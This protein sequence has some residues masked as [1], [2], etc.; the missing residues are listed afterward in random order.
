MKRSLLGFMLIALGLFSGVAYA[1]WMWAHG[2]TAELQ[3]P[4]NC[5]SR[6][7][8]GWGLDIEHK[9]GL[10]SWV[11]IPVP[12]KSGGTLAARYIKLRF[13]TGSVDAWVS[14]VDVWNGDT[15]VKKF[16]GLSYSNGWKTVSLDLGSPVAFNK[17][18]SLSVL[19]K[20]GVE[21][22]SHRLIFSGA[23]ASFTATP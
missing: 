12:S 20:A 15:P 5:T 17:G 2:N 22:M 9:P 11:H 8:M 23:G 18:M 10:S 4:G 16:T 3:S 13:Y 7:Y 1:E 14:Q 6:Y 21:S 19:V